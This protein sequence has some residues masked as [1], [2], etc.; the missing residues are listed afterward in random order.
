MIAARGVVTEKG[1]ST[2]HAAVV[3]RALGRPSVVGVG[4]GVTAEWEGAEVT[5]DGSGGVVY[6]HR[7][8]TTDVRYEDVPGLETLVLWARELSPVEVVDEAPDVLDL[9]ENGVQL[10]A[11]G[12]LDVEALTEHMRGAPAVTGSM[13]ATA[14][15][16]EAVLRAGIATVVARPGQPHAV[17]LLRLIHAQGHDTKEER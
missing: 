15:G 7:L 1:G 16:A 9:D 10:D 3:T 11:T 17:L 14:D 8:H 13:L 4:E 5:V 12:R 2:S 6:A